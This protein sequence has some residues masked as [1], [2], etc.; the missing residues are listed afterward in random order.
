MASQEF[1]D[2]LDSM[3][4]THEAKNA[5]YSGVGNPDPWANFRMAE[6]FGVSSFKGCLIRM[7]DKFI[8]LA[9]VIRNPANEQ[10]SESVEDTLI[11]LANYA[12]IAIC[13]WREQ[14]KK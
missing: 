13:L 10:V 4:A 12:I 5:G 11:D 3:R 9:N 8:R 6:T 7:S 2:L 14:N 1:L